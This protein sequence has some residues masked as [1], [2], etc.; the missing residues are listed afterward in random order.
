VVVEPG[1]GR[2]FGVLEGMEK[3]EVEAS[4]GSRGEKL[5]LIIPQI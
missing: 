4:S 1:M 2:L 5:L 3:E